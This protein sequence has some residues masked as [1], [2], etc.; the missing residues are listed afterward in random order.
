MST[1]PAE[2]PNPLFIGKVRLREDLGDGYAE[3]LRETYPDVPDSADLV[4]YWW[5]KAAQLVRLGK[6]RRFGLITTN[7]LRQT[8]AHRVV[9]QHLEGK[10]LLQ[11]RFL[12]SLRHAEGALHGTEGALHGSEGA[13]HGSEGALYGSEGALHG[14]EGGLKPASK[15]QK[16]PKSAPNLAHRPP[17]SAL[18][19]TPAKQPWPKTLAERI[20]AVEAALH[21]AGA[22]VTAADLSKHFTSTKPAALHEILE[23]LAAL[24]RARMDG[25]RFVV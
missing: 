17:S 15:P 4:L 14:S 18:R 25:E 21:A 1:L 9:Q 20:R 16:A 10:N 3:T 23:S 19:S 11:P 6:A 8:F 22:P 13:L 7:S 12:P 2:E 24:G 5:H